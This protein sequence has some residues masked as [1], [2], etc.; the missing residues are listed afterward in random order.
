MVES[1]R[2]ALS[3]FLAYIPQ[4]IGAIIILIVGYIIANV[5]Q[6]VVSRALQTIG[7]DRWMERG[8]IKQFFDRADTREM[9]T[10]ILGTLVFWFVF[11]IAIV[12]ATDALGIRQVS[13]VLAELIAYI[14]NVI[15]AVLIL[16]LAA[17]LANFLAGI[18]RGATG[19]DIL[20]TV[21]RVAI[22][23]YAVF[24]AL[25]QLGIAVQ[26]TANTLLI[27]LGG[28]A[29]A[30]AI[31]FG[32]GAQNVARDIVERAYDRRREEVRGEPAGREES[33]TQGDSVPRARPLRREE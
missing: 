23:V 14:P 11:I 8:G 2:N 26:L 15:A 24:A 5:L 21:A 32:F 3:V 9:P 31:A 4:L 28:V 1:L 20:A 7:F 22:I 13:A 25:T 33:L 6:A 18:I 19:S 27:V 30:A 12:M 10:S 17:L 29:L 16:I